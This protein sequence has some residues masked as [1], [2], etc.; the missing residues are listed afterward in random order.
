MSS[1]YTYNPNSRIA[2]RIKERERKRKRRRR[3][4]W[5]IIFLLLF[6]FIGYKFIRSADLNLP[7]FDIQAGINRLTNSNKQQTSQKQPESPETSELQDI[8]EDVLD[9][10]SQELEE[11]TVDSDPMESDFWGDENLPPLP[12]PSENNNFLDSFKNAEMNDKIC[13]L[14]FD[15]GPNAVTTPQILDILA[16]HQVKA[17]FFELGENLAAHKDIAQRTFDE[18][19]LL[20]NHT[21]TQKYSD[22]YTDADAFLSEVQ[23]TESLLTEII[24]TAPVKMIRFPGGS[25][26]TGTYASVKSECQSKLAENGYY[27][28]DWNMDNGDDGT[29]DSAQILEYVKANC[30]SKSIIMLFEDS[31]IRKATVSTLDD[32]LTYLESCGYTFC[33]LDNIFATAN[34]TATDTSYNSFLFARRGY[35]IY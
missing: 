21:Y 26:K 25:F 1:S 6:G 30:G 18:G 23:K 35:L 34:T 3:I 5:L 28:V 7:K 2:Q 29:R 8:E 16:K 17:S 32:V 12:A 13:C 11:E 20:L 19:H 15:D 22:V 27:F 31:N 14:T 24:G 33:R 10:E 4:T 9:T